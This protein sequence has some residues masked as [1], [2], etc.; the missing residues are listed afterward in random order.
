MTKPLRAALELIA[1]S[2]P[3]FK[4]ILEIGSRY[5]SKEKELT[6]LRKIFRKKNN[7]IGIDLFPG[8]GVDL[9]ADAENLPFRDH[10]FDLILCLETLEHAR[11]PWL[12]AR[13]IQRVLKKSGI[14]IVSSPF[15]HPLHFHP[16]DYYRYT[17]Y[18]LGEIF[19]FATNKLV[20]SISPPY[21]DEAKTHPQTIVF[22]GFPKN[23]EILKKKIKNTLLKNKNVISIHKPYRHRVK[24]MLRYFKRGLSELTFKLDI[25]FFK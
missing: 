6:D 9:T 12:I 11:K 4:E 8:D 3:E 10:Q 5:E 1:T 25:V 17:P 23:N 18:G 2:L 14:F 15:N 19:N 20:F 13:E 21:L 16:S 22:I 24:D 7:Y